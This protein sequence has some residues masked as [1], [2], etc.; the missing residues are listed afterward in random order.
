MCAHPSWE[1][2]HGGAYLPHRV[3]KRGRDSSDTAVHWDADT[4]R[5]II[6]GPPEAK[7]GQSG[8]FSKGLRE[9]SPREG[10]DAAVGRVASGASDLNAQFHTPH[11]ASK[12]GRHPAARLCH[13]VPGSLLGAHLIRITVEE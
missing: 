2:S 12:G 1:E 8:G 6:R 11:E 5:G 4:G 13:E 10:L 9:W 7:G 3:G